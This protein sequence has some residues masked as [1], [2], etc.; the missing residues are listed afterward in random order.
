MDLIL[1]S[2]HSPTLKF[3]RFRTP[4]S[5]L[6]SSL[7]LLVIVIMAGC[8]KPPSEPL[9]IVSSP[10]PGYEPLYLARDLGYLDKTDVRLIELPSSN[11]TLEAFSNGS[12]DI[13]TLTLDETLTLLAQDRKV[14]ILAIMD[15]SNGGDAVMAK[16][17]IKTLADMKNKRVAIV[18]IPLGIYM[19]RRTLESA[20]LNSEDVTVIAIPEDK[21]QKAYLR[22]EIDV[23]ITF[24]PF[25]T[26]LAEEGAHTLFDSSQIPNEIFD[27][28][29]VREDA[30]NSRREEL[31]KLINVWYQTLDYINEHPEDSARRMGKRL[32]M[33]PDSYLLAMQGLILPNRM[34]NSH[35]LGGPSPGLL[36]PAKRLEEI[37]QHEKMLPRSVDVSSAIDP[38]FQNCL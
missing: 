6:L 31:C 10:W 29:L 23:A 36:A 34:E 7:L 15:I 3:S 18:N 20:G 35:L 1:R 8:G 17:E 37:M 28:L 4:T 24:E 2:R 16:P 11:I 26:H 33:D 14:R 13:A 25:K 19:L 21:H 5:A 22:D 9:R 38:H 32:G 30:Y 27:L 12:A